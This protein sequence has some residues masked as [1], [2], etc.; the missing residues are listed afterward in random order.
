VTITRERHPFEGQSLAV[1]SSIRRRGVLLVL[2]V[3]PDGSRSLIPADWTDWRPSR[4][5]ERRQTM[6]AMVPTVSAGSAICF[7]CARSWTLFAADTSSRCR[8]RRAAMQLDLA[9]LDRPDLPP[10]PSPTVRSATAWEQL[11]EASRIAALEI[12][13]RLIARM[14]SAR[15]T[16]EASD[17]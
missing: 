15:S 14:L 17:E 8:A 9:F 4:P 10:N 2:V 6:P 12:L 1:I 11:D 16:R 7:T 13:A 5:G 3:L